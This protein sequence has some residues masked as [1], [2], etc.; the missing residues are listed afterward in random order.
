MTD[1]EKLDLLVNTLEGGNQ[2]RFAD[3]IGV[4]PTVLSKV[5]AGILTLRTRYNDIMTAYPQV[6][7]LWLETGEGYPGDLTIDLV[8]QNYLGII[9]E[10]DTIIAT[11]TKELALQQ[12]VIAQILQK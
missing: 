6:N 7:R 2:K 12:D 9:K 1:I 4:H 3:K 5:R 8:R 10:K 11:L